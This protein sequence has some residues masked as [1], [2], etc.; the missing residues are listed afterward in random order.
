[1]SANVQTDPSLTE[2]VSG[3]YVGVGIPQT[4]TSLHQNSCQNGGITPAP[5]T[6]HRDCG[7]SHTPGTDPRYTRDP[8]R[9]PP[10]SS[11]TR[12]APS[13]VAS[14]SSSPQRPPSPELP[15]HPSSDRLP[16]LPTFASTVP[17][18]PRDPLLILPAPDRK[19]HNQP[20]GLERLEPP[21]A[22]TPA[23]QAESLPAAS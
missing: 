16:P 22:A 7:V 8:D 10:H 15:S 1:M 14:S 23:A 20:H 5:E 17:L 6:E 2:E 4:D 9:L 18:S 13:P 11:Y 3:F 21:R 12:T 19:Q